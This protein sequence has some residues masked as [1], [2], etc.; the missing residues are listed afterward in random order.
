[1]TLDIFEKPAFGSEDFKMDISNEISTSGF[2][3]ITTLSQ[4]AIFYVR[5]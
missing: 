4:D 2:S 5:K 3:V 1:M